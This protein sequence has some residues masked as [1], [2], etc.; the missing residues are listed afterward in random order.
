M[1]QHI[2]LGRGKYIHNHHIIHALHT[3][4]HLHKRGAGFAGVQK[5]NVG[6]MSPVE[7]REGKRHHTRRLAPLKFKL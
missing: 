5:K 1:R 3:H 6:S 2:L 4:Q 7:I